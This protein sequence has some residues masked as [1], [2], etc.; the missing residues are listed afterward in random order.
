MPIKK[1]LLKKEGDEYYMGDFE[2]LMV[3]AIGILLLYYFLVL[4]SMLVR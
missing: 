2:F 1:G 3:L 4:I